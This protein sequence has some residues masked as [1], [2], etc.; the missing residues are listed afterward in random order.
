MDLIIS[1]SI[2]III[3]ITV[4]YL[5]NIVHLNAALHQFLN[6]V[7]VTSGS[8]QVNGCLSVLL[9]YNKKQNAKLAKTIN[10]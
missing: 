2:V 7:F 4:T 9:N 1:L 3:I 6:N 5:I 8:C 10:K